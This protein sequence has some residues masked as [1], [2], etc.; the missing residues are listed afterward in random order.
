L[1]QYLEMSGLSYRPNKA[2]VVHVILFIAVMWCGLDEHIPET[3]LFIQPKKKKNLRFSDLLDFN[4]DVI[5]LK[6]VLMVGHH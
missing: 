4:F 2:Y 1:F 3:P 5:N 6:L